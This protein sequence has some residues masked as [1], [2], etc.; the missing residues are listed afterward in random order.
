[1]ILPASSIQ[2][3]DVIIMCCFIIESIVVLVVKPTLFKIELMYDVIVVSPSR[4]NTESMFD[5]IVRP[6]L[7]KNE[8]IEISFVVVLLFIMVSILGISVLIRLRI[9]FTDSEIGT[10][11]LSNESTLVF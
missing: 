9:P 6:T 7:F 3:S 11:C 10:L 1:M 5:D 4:Y 2:Y 8:S